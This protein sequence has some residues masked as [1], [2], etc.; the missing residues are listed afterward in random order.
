[1]GETTVIITIILSNLIFLMFLGGIIMF[2]R[3]YKLKKGKHEE[4][5]KH[6]EEEHKKELLQ[7]QVEIQTQ[8]MAHIGRE[9]HDN[10][11]QKLTLASIYTK[12]FGHESQSEEVLSKTNMIDEILGESLVELR[13]LSKTL[14]DSSIGSYTIQ[15]LIYMEVEKIKS[16]QKCHV[17][18]NLDES[19]NIKSYHTKTV[20]VRV[21]QEFIQNSLK[22]ANCENIIVSLQKHGQEIELKIK[23]DGK[24]FDVTQ[25]VNGIGLKNIKKRVELIRAE[26]ELKSELNIGTE[27]K[28]KIPAE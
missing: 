5:L 23:D 28:I 24:G 27:L 4:E 26:L 18:C 7:T 2:I 25:K 8:T 21:V 12:Q 20:L 14:T 19:I 1:M 10:I 3:Q 11:G 13:R 15:Q 16:L 17:E 9:I 6:K 22:H